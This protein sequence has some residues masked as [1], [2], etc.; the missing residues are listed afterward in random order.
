MGKGKKDAHSEAKQKVFSA[1]MEGKSSGGPRTRGT[2][3][4]LALET[5]SERA[6]GCCT[7]PAPSRDALPLASRFGPIS[8]GV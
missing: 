8:L 4:H 7:N 3:A 1:L 5:L 6:G 2:C